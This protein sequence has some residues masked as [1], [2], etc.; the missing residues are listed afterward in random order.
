MA[1]D[2]KDNFVEQKVKYIEISDNKSD[3]LKEKLS[4]A[5]GFGV[6]VLPFSFAFLVIYALDMGAPYYLQPHETPGVR[7]M[8][9]IL[10]I[11]FLFML[12]GL[13]IMPIIGVFLGH[14]YEK[15]TGKISVGKIMSIVSI[16]AVVLFSSVLI[17]FYI[18]QQR[19]KEAEIE[20]RSEIYRGRSL[21]DIPP[22]LRYAPQVVK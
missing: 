18:V 22:E 15:A 3:R 5:F 7:D 8:Q 4:I 19:A 6:L 2:N 11:I 14:K 21:K 16:I 9:N 12:A 10:Q 13:V 1:R 20:R 17:L